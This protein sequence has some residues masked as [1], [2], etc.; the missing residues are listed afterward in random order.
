MI[1]FTGALAIATALVFALLPAQR[2]SDADVIDAL[3]DSSHGATAG[4]SNRRIR[5]SLVIAE[6]ALA[7]VLLTSALELTRTALS[8]N[9]LDRGV[10]TRRV[11]TAQCPFLSWS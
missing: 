2:A 7:V 4:A 9:N 11:M 1:A 8:L 6:L 5:A 10:D 3:K